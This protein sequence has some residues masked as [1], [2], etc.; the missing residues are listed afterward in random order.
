M[1]A[2]HHVIG[3]CT[4]ALLRSG[5]QSLQRLTLIRNL[6]RYQGKCMTT[7]RP[8]PNISYHLTWI[9]LRQNTNACLVLYIVLCEHQLNEVNQLF[10][11]SVL[12]LTIIGSTSGV[13]EYFNKK[14]NLYKM[15]VSHN[16]FVL[17]WVVSTNM[18]WY[19]GAWL[20]ML[21][22]S[23]FQEEDK[24]TTHYCQSNIFIKLY[25]VNVYLHFVDH[26]G[27]SVVCLVVLRLF[28]FGVRWSFLFVA[29][30]K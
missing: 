17:M 23:V 21:L 9:L 30:V 22:C 2:Q 26:N 27:L 25:R 20:S 18:T 8:K 15:V 7:C 6:R 10:G 19:M 5:L 12:I 28:N 4:L 3:G 11:G 13:M 1:L 29:P 16:T 24:H 14:R